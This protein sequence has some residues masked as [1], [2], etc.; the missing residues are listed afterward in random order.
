M[1]PP[2]ERGES[3]AR[4]PATGWGGGSQMGGAFLVPNKIFLLLNKRT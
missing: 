4:R 3:P 2:P 1:T